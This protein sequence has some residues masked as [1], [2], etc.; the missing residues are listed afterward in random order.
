[1][2]RSARKSTPHYTC[3]HDRTRARHL[4]CA[5]RAP[6]HRVALAW[7]RWP[8][9]PSEAVVRP[10]TASKLRPAAPGRSTEPYRRRP[11]CL[12]RQRPPLLVTREEDQYLDQPPATRRCTG[13]SNEETEKSSRGSCCGTKGCSIDVRNMLSDQRV[14]KSELWVAG[15][16]FANRCVRGGNS[17][18]CARDSAP[19]GTDLWKS[20]MEMMIPGGFVRLIEGFAVNSRC[21]LCL[22]RV[23]MSG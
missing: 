8:R 17:L 9:L 11:S 5:H 6:R 22:A 2:Q 1:M 15:A 20:T 21:D 14:H 3:K 19:E 4:Q 13:C 16:G 23:R 18:L 10:R 12:R 7:R